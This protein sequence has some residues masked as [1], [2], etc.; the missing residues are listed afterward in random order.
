MARGGVREHDGDRREQGQG[1][2]QHHD[3]GDGF[4]DAAH[5]S[6]KQRR[7]MAK[8]E[9]STAARESSPARGQMSMVLGLMVIDGL[10]VND[11]NVRRGK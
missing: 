6:R 11:G 1:D 2:G 10:M 3:G 5:L 7:K 4:V 9:V 8:G